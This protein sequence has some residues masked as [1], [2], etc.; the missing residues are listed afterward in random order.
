MKKQPVQLSPRALAQNKYNSARANLFLMLALTAVNII[1]LFFKSDYML[2]FSATVPYLAVLFGQLSG[3]T[4]GLVVG[5]CIAAIIILVYFLCWILSKKSYGWMIAALVLFS[6]DTIALVGFYIFAGE[7]SG[8]IDAAIHALVLYYLIV[9]TIN[10]IKLSKLP[11]E[12]E[13][14]EAIIEEELTAPSEE[15]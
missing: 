6:I 2:L 14:D 5:V 13:E 12:E 15:Q 4:S 11:E 7:F 10:G 9:G 8:I 3:V 1:L